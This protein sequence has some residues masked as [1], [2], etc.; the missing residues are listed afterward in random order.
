M[1]HLALL[2]ASIF[3]FKLVI[4]LLDWF[5]DSSFDLHLQAQDPEGDKCFIVEADKQGAWNTVTLKDVFERHK[6][7]RFGLKI[8]QYSSILIFGE[9]RYQL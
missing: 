1:Y 9:I 4:A 7:F 5:R 3:F 2:I 8:Y 6:G